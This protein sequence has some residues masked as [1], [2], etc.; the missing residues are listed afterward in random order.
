[1]KE[2]GYWCVVGRNSRGRRWFAH[3]SVASTRKAAIAAFLD[4]G[5][6]RDWQQYKACGY[7]VV[8]MTLEEGWR[9]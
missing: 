9:V 8:K 1:M 2:R 3:W 5:N 6:A 4:D 7:G